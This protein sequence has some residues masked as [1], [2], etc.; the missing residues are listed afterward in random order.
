M[1]V[2]QAKLFLMFTFISSHANSKAIASL[3]EMMQYTLH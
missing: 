1:E 3:A 2:L